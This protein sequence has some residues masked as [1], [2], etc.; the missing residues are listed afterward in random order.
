MYTR[1]Y[2]SQGQDA[3]AAPARWVQV[4]N[5][6]VVHVLGRHH[7]LDDILHQVFVDLVIAHICRQMGFQQMP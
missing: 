2:A 7:W 5:G 6:L 3:R 4:E 1:L